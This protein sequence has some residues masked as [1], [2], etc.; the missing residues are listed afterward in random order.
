MGLELASSA[1][2]DPLPFAEWLGSAT[3]STFEY[4]SQAFRDAFAGRGKET[5]RFSQELTD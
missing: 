5:I 4:G 1:V 3:A 2:R